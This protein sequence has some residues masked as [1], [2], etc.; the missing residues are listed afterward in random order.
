M[1]AQKCH[2]RCQRLDNFVIFDKFGV[3]L[4]NFPNKKKE[5]VR[6]EKH[7]GYPVVVERLHHSDPRKRS[8]TQQ[9]IE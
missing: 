3:I 8:K 6:S 5:N 4:R 1:F 2:Q 7:T 9:K